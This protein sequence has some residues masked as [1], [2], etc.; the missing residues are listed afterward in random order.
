MSVIGSIVSCVGRWR[1]C[2]VVVVVV[3]FFIVVKSISVRIGRSISWCVRVVRFFVCSPRRCS[4]ALCFCLVGFLELCVLA[5][6]PGAG[7]VWWFCVYW[8]W[9]MWCRFG[10]VLV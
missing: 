9:R 2:C 1:I 5:G 3:V 4:P 10:V 6:R 8:V 7:I